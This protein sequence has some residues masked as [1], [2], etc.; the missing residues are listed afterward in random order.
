MD[1]ETGTGSQRV[2]S[3]HDTW[4]ARCVDTC[5]AGAA[6]G[7][8]KPTGS[9]RCR[10]RRSDPTLRQVVVFAWDTSPRPS[11]RADPGVDAESGRGPLLVD[12]VSG[13][14]GHFA[15]DGGEVARVLLLGAS[16]SARGL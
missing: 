2:T 10:A 9:N 13:R 6:G 8:G 14:W 16:L 7:P 15:C 1:P 3:G 11:A 12:A 4:S 5:T